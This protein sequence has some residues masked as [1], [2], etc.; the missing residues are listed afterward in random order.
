MSDNR[1]CSIVSPASRSPSCTIN[2]E[3]RAIVSRRRSRAALGHSHSG[4][5]EAF[6][7]PQP[8]LLLLDEPTNHLAL[9]TIEWLEAT[10]AAQRGALVI[11][12]HDRRFLET[13][14]RVTVW[15][16]R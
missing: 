7:A 13:L 6:L 14:S 15:L 2:R 9:T 1:L 8:D 16:D 3:S 5:Q 11:I 12:S 4:T 10:L